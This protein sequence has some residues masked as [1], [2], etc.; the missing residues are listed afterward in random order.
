MP[1]QIVFHVHHP[2]LRTVRKAFTTNGTEQVAPRPLPKLIKLYQ[3][4]SILS[5]VMKDCDQ[6]QKS[7]LVLAAKLDQACTC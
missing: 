5:T 4:T 1:T 2:A 7:A 3:G 6:V